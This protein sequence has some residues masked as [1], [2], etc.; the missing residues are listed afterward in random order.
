MS[1]KLW[2]KKNN[3]SWV[4]IAL[5]DANWYALICYWT[6]AYTNLDEATAYQKG[7]LYFDTDVSTWTHAVYENTW[8]LAS[9]SWD[10]VWA[11]TAW[12][13]TLARWSVLAWNSSWVSAAVDI[14]WAWKI[15]AW[16]WTDAVA[17]TTLWYI[18]AKGS[19]TTSAATTQA[20]TVTWALATDL[21]FVQTAVSWTSTYTLSTAAA[22][23]WV[24][25]LVFGWDPLTTR[26]MKYV[27]V[28]W[29]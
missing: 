27:L 6:T 9:P 29:F 14:V 22:G 16:N 18:V 8:T 12:E 17:V 4:T 20:I 2:F 5:Q 13:I 19:H 23:S 3:D 10:L 11:T 26:V 28:R 25:D 21:A 1:N 24:I 15:I 7:C